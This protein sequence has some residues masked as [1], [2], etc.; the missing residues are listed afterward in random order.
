MSDQGIVVTPEMLSEHASYIHSTAGQITSLVGGM[1]SRMTQLAAS[2]WRGGASTRA[3]QLHEE[4]KKHH[5]AIIQATN[6]F[7]QLISR[8]ATLYAENEQNVGR[9]FIA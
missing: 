2:N 3:L 6:E 5:S 8:S 4:I 1:G 9:M 7:G